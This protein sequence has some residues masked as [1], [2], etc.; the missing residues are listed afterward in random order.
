[1]KLLNQLK[2][3]K[4]TVSSALGKTLAQEALKGNNDILSEAFE[5]VLFDDKN[6][7]S[8]AGKIIEQVAEKRKQKNNPILITME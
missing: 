6:V 1:M 2:N 3:N 8:G 4:G 7:R 5:L